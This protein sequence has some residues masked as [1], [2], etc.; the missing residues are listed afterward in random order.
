MAMRARAHLDVVLDVGNIAVP[1]LVPVR[2]LQSRLLADGLDHGQ[3]E[4]IQSGEDAGA[5]VG[6]AR[7]RQRVDGLSDGGNERK[8]ARD[9]VIRARVGSDPGVDCAQEAALTSPVEPDRVARGRSVGWEGAED[10]FVAERRDDLPAIVERRR[11]LCGFFHG[12][13]ARQRLQRGR[14]CFATRLRRERNAI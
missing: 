3:V 5:E 2:V 4:V 10:G 8:W 13:R 12:L 7:R 14:R 1:V 6:A 9:A 11:S